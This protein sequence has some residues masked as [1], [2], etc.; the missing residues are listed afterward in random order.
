MLKC[1]V[2]ITSTQFR[3]RLQSTIK[4]SLKISLQFDFILLNNFLLCIKNPQIGFPPFTLGTA[5]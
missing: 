2:D 1:I 3:C 5:I 4:L